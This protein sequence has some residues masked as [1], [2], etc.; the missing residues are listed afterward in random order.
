MAKTLTAAQR[1]LIASMLRVNQ[2][3][4][5]GAGGSL[6]RLQLLE[7]LEFCQRL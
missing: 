4:E 3:G 2:A 7:K 6:N 5:L 1:G